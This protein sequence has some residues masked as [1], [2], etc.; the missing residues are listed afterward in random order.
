[1]RAMRA[2]GRNASSLKYDILTALLAFGL[3]AE[4]PE[5]RLAPRLAVLMTARFNWQ[6][7]TFAVGQREIARLWGVTE[8]TA[9]R[10]MALLRA[11]GWIVVRRPAARGRVTE[12]AIDLERI[13]ADTAPVWPAIG[14]DFVARMA[15]EPA[16]AERRVVP[17]ARAGAPPKPDGSLWSAVSLRL[18][19]EDAALHA[20]WLSRLVQAGQEGAQVV[21]AAPSEFVAAYVRTHFGARLATAFAAVAPEVR[22]VRVV[23]G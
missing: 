18:W 19:R 12:H 9:K 1:M 4:G 21:L 13:V 6:A 7:G 2:T 11:R 3:H 8:R 20:A 22:E 17:F 15:P 10:E 16:E 5:A 23:A 14:P